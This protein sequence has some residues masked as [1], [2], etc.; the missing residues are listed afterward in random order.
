MKNPTLKVHD[1]FITMA[2][3]NTVVVS[4]IGDAEDE[5]GVGI[6]RDS[7]EQL[8]PQAVYE[9]DSPDEAA[10]VEVHVSRAV[11]SRLLSLS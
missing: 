5:N 3:C 2:I 1:F 11:Y 10:L 9:A 8:G 7:S 6:L 4:R